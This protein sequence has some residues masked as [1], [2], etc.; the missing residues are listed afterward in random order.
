MSINL[1]KLIESTGGNE[2]RIKLYLETYVEGVNEQMPNLIEAIQELDY[3]KIRT[4]MHSLKPL[5]TIL[6]FDELWKKANEI[7]INVDLNQ[8]LE[9]IEGQSKL[10]ELLLQDSLKAIKEY[11]PA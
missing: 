6:G 1:E 4:V 3:P 10:V 9:S 11:K 5:F 2:D 7:E 8:N